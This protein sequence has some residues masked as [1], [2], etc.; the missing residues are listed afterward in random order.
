[1]MGL[2][3]VRRRIDEWLAQHQPEVV[4]AKPFTSYGARL[5][6]RVMEYV[7]RQASPLPPN[8]RSGPQEASDVRPTALEVVPFAGA[9]GPVLG[10]YTGGDRPRPVVMPTAEWQA[11]G[12]APQPAD[13]QATGTVYL[14]L[15]GLRE[16][17]P[18]TADGM[19]PF[20][21]W[22]TGL[23]LSLAT[24]PWA[25]QPSLFEEGLRDLALQVMMRPIRCPS[26]RG[27]RGFRRPLVL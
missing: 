19:T 22:G 9:D 6:L 2:I 25:E 17:G 13:E 1:M 20:E 12:Y 11:A 7:A 16:H 27:L 15:P 14:H 26:Q 8:V 4:V 10:L 5:D 24:R 23:L 3:E 18:R 21:A